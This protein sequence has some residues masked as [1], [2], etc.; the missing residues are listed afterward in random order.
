MILFNK[1]KMFPCLIAA[2]LATNA[3]TMAVAQTEKT[4]TINFDDGE[5]ITG[6]ILEVSGDALRLDTIMG[7]VTIPMEGVSCIG[8][9]CP[10]TIRFNP[11]PAPV[12]LTSTDG[13]MKIGGDLLD[14]RDGSYLLAT[15]FGEI[16]VEIEKVA[17][18]GAG[19]PV[20]DVQYVFGEQVT[21]S[22]GTITLDGILTEVE[23]HAY[24][25][26]DENLGPIRVSK[27]FSCTGS[28]C[29]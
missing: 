4:V 8:I 27:E 18:S 21:L 16:K 6:D 2:V 23:S 26:E 1:I 14:I 20:R 13:T 9:A 28:G 7:A 17:C 3:T 19:C 15:D 22:N 24:L 5:G 12:T 29:P 11:A 10:E 25:I